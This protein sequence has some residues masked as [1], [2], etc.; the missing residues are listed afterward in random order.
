M[1]HPRLLRLLLI[2][3]LVAGLAAVGCSDADEVDSGGVSLVIADFDG[4]PIRISVNA[5]GGILQVEEIELQSI[6]QNPNLGTGN[7]Q[8]I[9]LTAYEVRYTRA[10]TGTRVPT[11]LVSGLLGT[12]PPGG[13]TVL[14]NLP[15]MLAEQ[16]LNPPIS[17][18][19]FVNGG[20][21]TETGG[22]VIKLNLIIRFFGRT[23]GGREVV[24]NAQSFLVEFVP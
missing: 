17:D 9:Q 24:S 16:M 7:L 6:V 23:L 21:D 14:E 3:P 19:L 11:P 10:D 4:L 20:F 5:S 12:V 22:E 13:T 15:L 8:T 1:R 18:L 2:L